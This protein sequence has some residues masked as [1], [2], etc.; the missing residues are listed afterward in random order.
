MEATDLT[1]SSCHPSSGFDQQIDHGRTLADIA[2]IVRLPEVNATIQKAVQDNTK[3]NS[4]FQDVSAT[5]DDALGTVSQLESL[6][7][8]LEVTD[9]FCGHRHVHQMPPRLNFGADAIL[10]YRELLDLCWPTLLC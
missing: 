10:T 8:N 5:Y 4:I 3:A 1:A 9:L 2:A 7:D 6:V